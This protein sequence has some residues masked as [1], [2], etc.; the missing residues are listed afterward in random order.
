MPKAED[1]TEILTVQELAVYLHSAPT[2]IYRLL[3]SGRIP[4]FR[5]GGSWRFRMD[6]IDR[7][8]QQGDVTAPRVVQ[9]PDQTREVGDQRSAVKR[10]S[11]ASKTSQSLSRR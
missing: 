1:R 5:L 9:G 10:A 6:D 2:T 3:K 11:A 4:A 7:W 8:I